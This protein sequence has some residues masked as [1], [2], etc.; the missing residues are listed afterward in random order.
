MYNGTSIIDVDLDGL[1]CLEIKLIGTYGLQQV[2]V[3]IEVQIQWSTL[4]YRTNETY[5]ISGLSF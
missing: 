5:S 3:Y 1:W 2:M 4:V